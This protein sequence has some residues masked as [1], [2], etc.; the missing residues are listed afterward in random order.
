MTIR[1]F[2][3]L[4][5]AGLLI[6]GGARAEERTFGKGV[7]EPDDL[8]PISQLL[9]NPADYLDQTVRVQGDVVGI[10]KKRGCW[11]ELTSDQ[12]F[13]TI[14]IKVEDGEIV[15]PMD[16]LG[17]TAI[18]EG[19]FTALP[20][21]LEQTRA[22]LKHETEC[23]GGKFDVE[24]VTEAMTLYRIQGTGAIVRESEPIEEIEEPTL[25]DT[26]EEAAPD[27]AESS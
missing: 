17:S 16:L 24:S 21:T 14:Q 1:I 6:A 23:Q 8:V 2:P 3:A 20:L 10:C 18:A 12:E 27:R 7:S 15:F 19:V 13:Q 5:L 9:A 11:M 26:T 25:D 4:A 22:Y